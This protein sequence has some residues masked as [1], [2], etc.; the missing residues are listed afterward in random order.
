LPFSINGVHA[1]YWFDTG[2]ELSVL[3]ESEAK[4][5]GLRERQ[6]SVEVGDV[7]GTQV[8]IRIAIADELAIGSI[9]IKHVAFLVLPDNQPP[10]NEQSSGSRGLIGLPVL[11][12]LPR[13]VWKADRTFEI[14]PGSSQETAGH[15]ALCFDGNH[16]LVLLEY[17][18]H[19]LEFAWIRVQ[20]IQTFTRRL[21]RR[22]QSSSALPQRRIR[23]K[24]KGWEGRST[25]RRHS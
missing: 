16:P 21:H 18:N 4:R 20:R 22:F 17:D 13:F 15:V 12:S 6:A 23:T 25:W 8:K 9:R 24:W 3:T 10:F 11:L 19:P 1:T 7:N 2:A 14:G 5:F